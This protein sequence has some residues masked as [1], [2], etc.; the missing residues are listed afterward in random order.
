MTVPSRRGLSGVTNAVGAVAF[1]IVWAALVS[2]AVWA[3]DVLTERYNN[4]RTGATSQP[5]NSDTFRRGWHK[6]GELS[7]SGRV[8]AQPLFVEGLQ[9][10][11][12]G[13]HRNVVFIATEQ[14]SVYAYDAD[15]LSPIW[16]RSLGLAVPIGSGIRRAIAC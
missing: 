2:H 11:A 5:L 13:P 1:G 16:N 9:M 4:A 10:S 3:Q 6:L 15:S 8:Y 12:G 14:N 7:V